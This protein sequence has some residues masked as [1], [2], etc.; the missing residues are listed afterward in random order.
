M[1]VKAVTKEDWSAW[2]KI[3]KFQDK[4]LTFKDVP[5]IREYG[6]YMIERIRDYEKGVVDI[7]RVDRSE[8]SFIVQRLEELRCDIAD[9]LRKIIKQQYKTGAIGVY[10]QKK[11][12]IPFV[13]IDNLE[14]TTFFTPEDV[15]IVRGGEVN[16]DSKT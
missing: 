14:A 15:N 11:E 2:D 12:V 9:K 16:A 3:A 1:K 10:W 4:I 6:L 8:I 7:V 13:S 5:A